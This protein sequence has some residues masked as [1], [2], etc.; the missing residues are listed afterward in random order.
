MINQTLQE[1]Y[2]HLELTVQPLSQVQKDNESKRIDSEYFKKEYLEN[3]KTITSD[4]IIANFLDFRI[5]NIKNL[6]LKK[7]FQYLQIGDVNLINGLDYS[8]ME[9]EYTNIPDRA[10]Y[11]LKNNDI[12]I[13]N[14]RPNRNAVALIN[15]PKRL[16]GTSGFTIL[17]LKNKNIVPQFLY[18]FCKTNFFLTRMMRVNAASLYPA[19]LDSD[20]YK[21]SIPILPM[22][23]QKEI[24]K[25]VKDSY[26]A[27]EESKNLYKKAQDTLY[28]SLGLNPDLDIQAQIATNTYT[29]KS[30]TKDNKANNET[31]KSNTETKNNNE[32][33]EKEFQEINEIKEA[34]KSND[35]IESKKLNISIRTLKE[36]FLKTGRLDSEYYQEKYDTMESHLK[37]NGFTTLK[38]NMFFN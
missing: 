27:L 24:K 30:H 16:I 33:I 36:S 21:M 22:C 7:N 15:K 29:T 12:C 20:I 35:I 28:L 4:F 3:E 17:R 11:V 34:V 9:I 37:K 14:V 26:K 8:S 23:F 1:K 31:Q 25:M 18:V 13:S 19:I 6:T 5:K 10:T 2:P 38:K 32:Y